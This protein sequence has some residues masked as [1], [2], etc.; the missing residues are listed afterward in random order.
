MEQHRSV[1]CVYGK[2][3]RLTDPFAS[4][5][6]CL[7]PK[8]YLL[9]LLLFVI[10][11]ARLRDSSKSVLR[12][13]YRSDEERSLVK[14]SSVLVLK[15]GEEQNYWHTAERCYELVGY[16]PNYKRKG[17]NNQSFKNNNSVNANKTSLA[18]SSSLPFTPEQITKLIGLVSQTDIKNSEASSSGVRV[19][20]QPTDTVG[21]P[22][23]AEDVTQ[24][25]G[26]TPQVCEG[27]GSGNLHLNEEISLSEGSSSSSGGIN[28]LPMARPTTRTSNRTSTFP[29]NCEVAPRELVCELVLYDRHNKV[30][31]E[32][33]HSCLHYKDQ[34]RLAGLAYD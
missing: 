21:S 3:S 1:S 33:D 5:Q 14:G 20:Q 16:P 9:D 32:E 8:R 11:E 22:D 2:E 26:L 25:F 12:W 28:D 6:I 7:D 15:R 27:V 13:N 23:V 29:Q 31:R 30:L 19:T 34:G 4:T 10:V 24:Q 18:A 17:N